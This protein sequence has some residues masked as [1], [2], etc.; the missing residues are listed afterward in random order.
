MRG[1]LVVHGRRTAHVILN[2]DPKPNLSHGDV[3]ALLGQDDDVPYAANAYADDAG[4]GGARYR[5]EQ[6][7]SLARDDFASSVGLHAPTTH[8]EI[9]RRPGGEFWGFRSRAAGGKMLQATRKARRRLVFASSHFGTWEEWILLPG[10]SEDLSSPWTTRDLVFKNR[11]VDGVRLRVTALRVGTAI[12]P[13]LGGVSTATSLANSPTRTSSAFDDSIVS[14]TRSVTG[15][16][17][18]GPEDPTLSFLRE[19]DDTLDDTDD[20][21]LPSA[22]GSPAEFFSPTAEPSSSSDPSP[23][24]G[25][26]V[27]RDRPPPNAFRRPLFA[28]GG[29][30]PGSRPGSR[31]GSTRASPSGRAIADASFASSSAGG[32]GSREHA[33]A[34]RAMGGVVA[35]EFVAALTKEVAARAAIEKE[36]L[37]LH[38][39]SEELREWALAELD[40]LRA[41]SREHVEELARTI[42]DHRV[43]AALADASLANAEGANEELK[44]S[45]R[46]LLTVVEHRAIYACGVFARRRERHVTARCFDAWWSV[47]ADVQ[48]KNTLLRRIGARLGNVALARAR[49][50]ERSR[51]GSDR[52]AA[53]DASAR[54]AVVARPRELRV[55]RV[56]VDVEVGDHAPPRDRG[57]DAKEPEEDDGAGVSSVAPARS[58]DSRDAREDGG[59]RRDE[60]G[61]HERAAARVRVHRDEAPATDGVRRDV[62]VE[63][64]SV[65][66]A[67]DAAGAHA[68]RD[69]FRRASDA[70]VPEQ[71]P[72]RVA[73][74]RVAGSVR[75]PRRRAEAR[76]R[77]ARDLPRRVR[78]VGEL[79]EFKRVATQARVVDF[80]AKRH[81]RD[82]P[83]VAR[84]EEDVRRRAR[85]A[86]EDNDAR[87]RAARARA[88][89]DVLRVVARQGD[90]EA[91]ETRAGVQGG[92]TLVAAARVQ[93]VSV[94]VS[95]R[96][97]R[98]QRPARRRAVPREGDEQRLGVRVRRVS[99]GR[100]AAE[101]AASV[102][103]Q[104]R[105]ADAPR[106]FIARVLRLGGE[107]VRGGAR[108]T[109]RETRDRVRR[110][111]DAREDGGGVG[112]GGARDEAR[113][114]AGDARGVQSVPLDPM[115]RV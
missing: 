75:P 79:G 17:D 65:A 52:A 5:F 66:A 110:A 48:R 46:R 71:S 47:H 58:F 73:E 39:S 13:D 26:R 33:S 87:G 49:R 72:H 98:A 56:G 105:G 53:P 44:A 96:S 80:R 1:E 3:V 91:A 60:D 84:V 35:K 57:D 97:T 10:V 51:L 2:S 19:E 23:S 9:V 8:L 62:G 30:G 37:R 32:D 111:K 114:R 69:A 83:R 81:P 11:R 95:V 103:R 106:M 115:A 76:A 85:A 50:L 14:T 82:R 70:S 4:G 29:S 90:G 6:C 100:D 89:D 78:A 92:Q 27:P 55:S 77:R 28:E 59:R 36:V 45:T 113:A 102:V 16:G 93:R 88:R 7:R 31:P 22:P 42:E 63:R 34:L 12:D 94:L 61:A 107:R 54:H 74:R 15:R 112:G 64:P 67:S 41:Y 43:N 101:A 86:A 109:A 25:A 21:R 38:S 40:L 104:R 24:R 68:K 20:G 99:R 18:A 108:E